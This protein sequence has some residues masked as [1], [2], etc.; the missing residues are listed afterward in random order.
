VGRLVWLQVFRHDELLK[1]AHQQQQKT[2]EV[3]A[4]RGAIVDRNGQPLAKSLPSESICVNPMKIPDPGVAADLL[5][6]LLE[7]DRRKLFDRLKSAK[8]R[9]TGFLWVKRKASAEEAERV[10]SLKLEWVEF[11]PEMR[12]FYPHATLAS[13]VVGSIGYSDD[14]DE[15]GNAGIEASFD[16][17]LAGRPGLEQ[18]FTDVKQNPYDSLVS[19]RP[20]PGSNLTLS[21]DSNLQY[22][23]ERELDKAV[24]SSGAATGTIVVL[25]PYTGDVLAM[26]NYPRF[27]PNIPPGPGEPANA[28]SNLAVTTPFEPG[29]VFKVITIT[30]ALESTS[31]RPETIINCGNGSIK[32]FGRVIHDHDSYAALP[33]ADVLAKSSNIG[34][35]NIGLKVGDRTL[36]NYVRKYGFGKKTGIELPGESTGMVRRVEQWTPSSIGSV[37]MGHEISTTSLQLALAGAAVANGGLLI[38]PRLVIARQ[39]PGQPAETFA[40]ERPERIMRPETAIQMRQMMEGVVLHGTGKKAALAG[41]TSGGKT[42]SAQVYDL[43]SHVYTHTYNASFLGFAPVVNPQIVVAVTLNGTTH[44]QAGFGGAVAAPVFREVATTALR[45]FDVPKDLPDS[46]TLVTENRAAKNGTS[47]AG[48][49][50]DDRDAAVGND[51][52]IAGLGEA[53]E[54]WESTGSTQDSAHGGASSAVRTRAVSSVTPPP[55]HPDVKVS[56]EASQ[57]DRRPFLTA[58]AELR[59]GQTQA[60]P[61]PWGTREGGTR[62]GETRQG[63]THQA[64][65]P[66]FGGTKVPDLRGLPLSSVLAEAAAAGLQVEVHGS[67]MARDQEPPPGAYLPARAAIRVQFAK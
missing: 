49:A 21:L 58:S 3:Q 36:Y 16:E 10:R 48:V 65:A 50:N 53:P 13:H 44:G 59:G 11:R 17:D 42:G 63:G 4:V 38:K 5:S 6:R 8:H 55:V 27:D 20:E 41:Y 12:R 15:H 9:G 33:M 22:T 31:L 51:L 61:A 29:S 52:A 67:G 64:P 62:E 45:I 40:P 39:K 60:A 2:V 7:M 66:P 14:S 26:A 25:N 46:S 18:V 19:R 37:A 35:I 43:R 54:V 30:A 24:Q 23:A 47:K 56:A 57:V 28:R 34:A 1:L 32:L